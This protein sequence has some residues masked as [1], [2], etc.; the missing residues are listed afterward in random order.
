[1]GDKTM[2]TNTTTLHRGS[3]QSTLGAFA[4]PLAAILVAIAGLVGLNAALRPAGISP[5]PASD[6]AVQKA[7]LD[8]RAGE[9]D[10][11]SIGSDA[12]VQKAL[13]DV[14][15]GERDSRGH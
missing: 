12:A 4:A 10:S 11:L 7:L 9:R 8:V 14:R 5:A 2:S 6:A 1:M 13:L 15:A 3:A